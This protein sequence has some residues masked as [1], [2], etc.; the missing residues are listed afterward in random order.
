MLGSLVF[1]L[2]LFLIPTV[3]MFYLSFSYLYFI[4]IVAHVTV[5]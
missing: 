1:T 5:L 3:F 4:I 2:I